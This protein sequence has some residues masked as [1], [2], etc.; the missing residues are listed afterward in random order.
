MSEPSHDEPVSGAALEAARREKL[1]KIRELGID[2]WGHR[3][4]GAEA[5]GRIRAREN[6]IVVQPA[7]E[8]EPG[9][10]P[11]QHGPQVRAAGRIVLQR[12]AGKLLFVD[13]RDWTGKVQL[14][15]GKSQVGER[16][17]ELA[18]CLDLGDIIGVDGQ[19]GR[20]RMGE[21][22]IFVSDLHF[23]TKSIETP[24]DKHKGLID[25]ELRQRMRYLDL[26]YTE[27]VWERF[28]RR[29]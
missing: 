13:I 14:L 4:D 23:L 16:N 25:P 8:G 22:S 18:Q 1:R 6:E 24:P 28:L 12:R 20:T 15:I 19:L 17:W 10:P 9:K 11:Q 29:T 3:F 2:P 7:G 27:G 5:I 26:V 21:L